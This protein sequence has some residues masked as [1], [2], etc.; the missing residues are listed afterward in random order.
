LVLFCRKE[1]A[2][3]GLSVEAREELRR[4]CMRTNLIPNDQTAL[5][6]LIDAANVIGSRPTGWWRDRPVAARTF[7]NQVHDAVEA[8]QIDDSVVMVLEGESRGGFEA[9]VVGGVE[10]L[11]AE[12]SGDDMLINVISGTSDRVTLV[13]AD[14]ELRERAEALGAEVV[15]PRWLI[16]RLEQ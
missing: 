8:G 16:Q 10:V 6:L 5:M 15:G 1:S 12:A 9:G 4:L 2:V 7:V 11:H 14:R 3:G 13:T